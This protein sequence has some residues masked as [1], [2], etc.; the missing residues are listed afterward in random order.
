MNC[1]IESLTAENRGSIKHKLNPPRTPHFSSKSWILTV[2]KLKIK[3]LAVVVIEYFPLN[4]PHF[5]PKTVKI[6]P[7]MHVHTQILWL[8]SL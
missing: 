1:K 3:A 6:S 4:F 5:P 2:L 7:L 8:I